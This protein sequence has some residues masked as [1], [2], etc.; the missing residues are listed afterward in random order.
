MPRDQA[1]F[2]RSMTFSVRNEKTRL[3]DAP[4]G[5]FRSGI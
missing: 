1:T 5:S 3:E 2:E 4:G